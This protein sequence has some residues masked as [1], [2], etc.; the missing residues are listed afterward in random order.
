M[1]EFTANKNKALLPIHDKTAIEYIIEAY[2]EDAEF[3]FAIGYLGDQLKDFVGKIFPERKFTWVVVENFDGYGSGP[4]LSL[5]A[6]K[7]FLQCPFVLA[8]VD[9]LVSGK[10]PSPDE[11]WFGVAPVDDTSRFCSVSVDEEENILAIVDKQKTTNKYAFTGIAGI[12]DYKLFWDSLEDNKK[13][14]AGERQV[15]NG[16]QAL[17]EVGMSIRVLDWFDTGVPEA[18][19]A[20]C[21][22][23]PK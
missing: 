14:V 10:V 8:N 15:S 11:N 22:N 6:C 7:D 23:F 9:A 16:F 21:R 5:L 19:E 17:R 12:Y 2:P 1:K 4:G 3:V 20:T 18:Y 13:L